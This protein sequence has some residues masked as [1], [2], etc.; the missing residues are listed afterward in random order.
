MA[1]REYDSP[2]ANVVYIKQITCGDQQNMK[3]NEPATSILAKRRRDRNVDVCGNGSS[4]G[5]AFLVL[6]A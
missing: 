1:V 2:A 3:T 4:D 6:C 5:A